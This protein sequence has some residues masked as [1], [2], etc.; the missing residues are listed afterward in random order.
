MPSTEGIDR[1]LSFMVVEVG[2]QLD[3]A[4]QVM[5]Q[6]TQALV[7][8][9]YSSDNYIDTL[10]GFI[11]KKTI[12]SFRNT[13]E[14]DRLT[15]G[16]L[17]ALTTIA[18]NL[19][20]IA[21]FCANIGG[22][23]SHMTDAAVLNRYDFAPYQQIISAALT[24]IPEAISSNDAAVALRICAA[25]PAT[26]ALYSGHVAAIKADLRKGEHTDDL[27]A[28]LYVFHYL[29]RMGDALQNVGEA[30][31]Y[32]ITGEKLKLHERQTLHEALGNGG[33]SATDSSYAVDFRYETR[34]G[35]RIGKVTDRRAAD[36]AA[37]AIFKKGRKE[38]LAR[39][40]ANIELW[41]SLMPGVPP[42]ILEY[43]EG[44][45]NGDAALLLEYLDGVTF[46]EMVL[47]AESAGLAAAQRA[48]E[49]TLSAAWE[50]TLER[51][52]IHGEFLGQL[53]DRLG[54]VWRVHPEFRGQKCRVGR[55]QFRT[56][57]DMLAEATETAREL[58]APFRVMIHGDLNA[59]N[60][61]V[62]HGDQRVHFID[63]YRSRPMDYVQDVSV[64]LLSNFRMPVF[65]RALRGRIHKVILEFHAFARRFARQH[66][67]E[68]FEARLALGLMRSFMTST[69]F[70][71]D[72][73]FAKTMY[74]RA[75]YLMEKL[76]AHKGRPWAEFVLNEDALLY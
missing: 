68:S 63:L 55:L 66:G 10:K 60:I 35:T 56:F 38:K 52:P 75:V 46:N 76:I 49:G 42:R 7:R 53:A 65:D 12:S 9:I 18:N 11:E 23:M 43:R 14:M 61:I 20:R 31:L 72:E 48:I 30:A 5:R 6:P 67:D 34:S 3:H 33:E 36:A 44:E 73:T 25:E 39:E 2:K 45:G 13:A 37:E 16:R 62:G 70:E 64:F 58:E 15:A 71:L 50:R 19:E 21:D 24:E 41:E 8:K 4:F 51:E 54:D 47:N 74:L 27:V 69:R 59:D 57:E 32:A 17:R 1:N 29:E 26:D 40:R 28:C 22:Q